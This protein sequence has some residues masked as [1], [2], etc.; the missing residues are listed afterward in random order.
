VYVT[1]KLRDVSAEVHAALAPITDDL[2]RERA[3]ER[4]E[5]TSVAAC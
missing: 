5:K 2:E 1:R 4:F 3:L